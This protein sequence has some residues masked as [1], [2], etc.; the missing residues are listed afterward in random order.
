MPLDHLLAPTRHFK[1]RQNQ[2]GKPPPATFYDIILIP[3]SVL[4]NVERGLYR[5]KSVTR[6]VCHVHKFSSKPGASGDVAID[7]TAYKLAVIATRCLSWKVLLRLGYNFA[8]NHASRIA[9]NSPP[10]LNDNNFMTTHSLCYS[11]VLFLFVLRQTFFQGS[12]FSGVYR[13]LPSLSRC[14]IRVLGDLRK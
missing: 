9:T 7:I 10:R 2:R 8:S 12:V 5:Q 13:A 1:L 14:Y 4:A 3:N 11:L 6:M